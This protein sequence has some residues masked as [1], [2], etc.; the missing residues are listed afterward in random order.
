MNAYPNRSYVKGTSFR[1][2]R[3][4]R[5]LPTSLIGKKGQKEIEHAFKQAVR[6][7]GSFSYHIWMK[8]MKPL[9]RRNGNQFLHREA[10]DHRDAVKRK[11]DCL[12][13]LTK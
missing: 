8:D 5:V 3:T 11:I 13:T 4:L 6:V 7:I 9:R 1:Y 12:D 10:E 2:A